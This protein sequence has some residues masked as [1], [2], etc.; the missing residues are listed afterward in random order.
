MRALE[1]PQRVGKRTHQRRN[2]RAHHD[3]ARQFVAVAG[4]GQLVVAGKDL[5]DLRHRLAAGGIQNNRARAA[6]KQYLVQFFLERADLQADR[7]SREADFLA[8]R[9]KRAVPGDGKENLE[10]ADRG[11]GPILK[12]TFISYK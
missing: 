6:V 7:G 9:G 11:H 12:Q 2:K 4:I 8:G 1:A 3:V 5:L 10:G